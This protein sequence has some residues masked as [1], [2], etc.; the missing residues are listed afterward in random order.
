MYFLWTTNLIINLKNQ[1]LLFALGGW[2]DEKNKP[3]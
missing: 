3:K 1:P 2:L